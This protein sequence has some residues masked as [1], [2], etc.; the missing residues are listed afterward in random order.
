MDDPATWPES[1]SAAVLA[2]VLG[3]VTGPVAAAG[4]LPFDGDLD[5]DAEHPRQQ[6]RWELGGELEESGGAGLPGMDADCT[7]SFGEP[8]GAD[9]PAWLPAGEQPHRCALI[10]ECGMAAAGGDEVEHET[11]EGFGNH[12][13]SSTEA[14]SHTLG[15][16]GVTVPKRKETVPLTGPA[17]HEPF[18]GKGAGQS[19]CGPSYGQPFL[20]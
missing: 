5:V 10:A 12:D 6:R 15:V 3:G 11:G 17:S 7:E 4:T 14:Q 20:D 16:S 9:G 1:S 19:A 18:G 2:A 8:A 13:G